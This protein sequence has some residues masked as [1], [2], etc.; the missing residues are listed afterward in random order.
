MRRM[1]ALLLVVV[2]ELGPVAIG[3]FAGPRELAFIHQVSSQV[4]P[5]PSVIPTD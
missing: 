1:G 2:I 3:L 4:P 5:Y